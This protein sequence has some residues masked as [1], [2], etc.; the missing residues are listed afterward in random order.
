MGTNERK[1]RQFTRE[2]VTLVVLVVVALVGFR[3]YE[4]SRLAGSRVGITFKKPDGA[5]SPEF[6]LELA[7][8]GPAR[9]KGL[10][11][12]KPDSIPER[13]GMMFVF[14]NDQ[15]LSFWMRNTLTP[16]DILFLDSSL[17]VQ[18]VLANVPIMNETSRSIG[19]EGRY[20]IELHA[21]TAGRYGIG[22]GAIAIPNRP[23]P[24]GR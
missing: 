10:M 3:V 15:I 24:K 20:V 11:F 14:P 1:R 17:T 23:I 21:G 7:L 9:S 16:L 6:T 12:R 5:T 18:G 8:D 19:K 22:E 2:I 4:S 13:G